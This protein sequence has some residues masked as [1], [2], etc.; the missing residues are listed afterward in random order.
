MQLVDRIQDCNGCGACVVAC[1]YRCVK[2]KKDENGNNR[3]V[4]NETGAINATPAFFSAP[5]IIRWICRNL[6]SF[7]TPLRKKMSAAEIWLRFTGRP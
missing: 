5:Y 1:K 4:V 3:P 2:M 7:M 6:K